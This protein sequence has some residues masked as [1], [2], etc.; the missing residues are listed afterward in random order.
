M[1]GMGGLRSEAA[2]LLL[3][4][5]A[6]SRF[7]AT[8]AGA[9]YRVGAAAA[10]NVGGVDYHEWASHKVF[11]V[12]DT[13]S[14]EYNPHEHNVLRVSREDYHSCK[15]TSPIAT[16]TSGNDSITIMGPGHYYYICGFEGHCQAGQ[17]IDIRVP[18]T[19]Q[20]VEVPNGSPAQSPQNY[21]PPSSSPNYGPPSSSPNYGAPQLSPSYTADNT[22]GAPFLQIGL[23]DLALLL[24]IPICLI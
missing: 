8:A 14:F 18:K 23:H 6:V 24:V 19:N 22:S 7:P 16:Y 21:G 2:A 3:T 11:H 10:W 4:L 17:K 12:G 13:F 1:S 5:I 20:R 9:Q 15:T